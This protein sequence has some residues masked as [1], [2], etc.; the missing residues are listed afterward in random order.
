ML[1]MDIDILSAATIGTMGN[2]RKN[3]TRFGYPIWGYNWDN[4][5]RGWEVENLG[6]ENQDLGEGAQKRGPKVSYFFVDTGQVLYISY[7]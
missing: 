4:W 5:N 1:D 6:P 7:H 3:N 2:K